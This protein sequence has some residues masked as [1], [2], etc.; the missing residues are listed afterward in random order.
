MPAPAPRAALRK[1]FAAFP[2]FR[3]T[4]LETLAEDGR[5]TDYYGLLLVRLEGQRIA[6]FWAQPDQLGILRQL[7]A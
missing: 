5:A 2:D 3:F 4:V 1:L 6:S 7:G